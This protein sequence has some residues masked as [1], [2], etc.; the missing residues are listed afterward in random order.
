MAVSTVT[1]YGG[2]LSGSLSQYDFHVS[3]YTDNAGEPGTFISELVGTT[4]N[5]VGDKYIYSASPP[6]VAAAATTYFVVFESSLDINL[7]G[8]AFGITYTDPANG[9]EVTDTVG[10]VLDDSALQSL[11]GGGTWTDIFDGI[12]DHASASLRLCINSCPADGGVRPWI[13]CLN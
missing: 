6:L 11:D 3:F 5:G 8:G 12:A 1:F 13:F 4:V 2:R 9:A 7:A 10:A